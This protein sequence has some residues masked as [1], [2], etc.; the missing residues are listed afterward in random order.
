MLGNVIVKY[1]KLM[2]IS[3]W[4]VNKGNEFNL[5]TFWADLLIW[6]IPISL[7]LALIIDWYVA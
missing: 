4:W 5:F 6:T 1:R 2:I 3:N 7:G